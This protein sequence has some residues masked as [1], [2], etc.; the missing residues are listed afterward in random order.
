M[1]EMFRESSPSVLFRDAPFALVSS[2][3]V[4]VLM[5]LFGY[6]V[7]AIPGFVLVAYLAQW[8]AFNVICDAMIFALSR[9]NGWAAN[10]SAELGIERS[11]TEPGPIR[12]TVAKTVVTSVVMLTIGIALIAAVLTVSL[13]G[14]PSVPDALMRTAVVASLLSGSVI[15]LYLGHSLYV[16]RAAASRLRRRRTATRVLSLTYISD[17]RLI[18]RPRRRRARIQ[19]LTELFLSHIMVS[20]NIARRHRLS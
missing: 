13:F 20:V 2:T 11:E 5:W 15:L 16:L 14:F 3:G 9:L 7:E 12:L 1:K 18:V 17:K 8:V 10:I 6:T 4:F 19:S